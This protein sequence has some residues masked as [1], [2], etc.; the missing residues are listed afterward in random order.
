MNTSGRRGRPMETYTPRQGPPVPGLRRCSDGRWRVRLPDG[1]RERFTEPDEDRAVARAK[2]LIA[3]ERPTIDVPIDLDRA[4]RK[5]DLLHTALDAA[6][7]LKL[8]LHFR[9][10]E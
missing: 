2:A 4:P 9:P 6:R 7:P 1:R 5:Q 3:A 8:K 10:G